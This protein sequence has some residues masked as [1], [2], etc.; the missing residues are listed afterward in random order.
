VTRS[1]SITIDQLRR[2]AKEGTLY[3]LLD[4]CDEP[5]IPQ[6][7]R[8]MPSDRAACLYE[9]RGLAEF[10]HVAPYI[11]QLTLDDLE[12]IGRN[13]WNK[14]WG[15]FI[16]ARSDLFSLRTH[17]RRFLTVPRPE[18]KVMLFRFY[19]PRVIKPFLAARTLEQVIEFYGPAKGFALTV[20]FNLATVELVVPLSAGDR[21]SAG[22]A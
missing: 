16:I 3:A 4:A 11:F 21:T 10:W 12:W 6:R 13:L 9:G 2:L 22:Y 5:Q 15:Y 19:D 1:S 14:P 20:P 7:C 17:F 8:E 18:G